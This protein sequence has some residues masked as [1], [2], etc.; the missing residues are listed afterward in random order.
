M[1]FSPIVRGVTT[2]DEAME[3]REG[4]EKYGSSGGAGVPAAVKEKVK[5]FGMAK[6]S[7]SD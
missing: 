3:N 6:N 7:D 4:R 1:R 2:L 5:I